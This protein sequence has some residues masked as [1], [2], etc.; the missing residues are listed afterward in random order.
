MQVVIALPNTDEINKLDTPVCGMPLLVRVIATALRSGGT[1]VLLVLPPR[2]SYRSLA[3]RLRSNVIESARIETL[4]IDQP[5]D[6]N[7]PE[8]WRA[9]AHRLDERFLWMPNDYL[10]DRAALTKLLAFSAS[11]PGP[12][13]FS[14]VAE[15]G[16]DQR[17]F[18]RPAVLLKQDRIGGCRAQFQIVAV[19]GQ[20]GIS[21]RQP[22]DAEP[23]LIRRAGKTT[24]GVYSRLNRKLSAPMVRWLSYTPV[25]PNMVS[26]GGLIVAIGAGLCFAQG[27]WAW[28]VAG[29][30]LFFLSGM[31]D[32]MDGMLARLKFQ[33]S[34]F[35]CW[36]ETI[37]DYATYLLIFAGM[38]A[39]GY[40]RGGL[41]Y[42]VLGAALLLGCV[43]AFIAVGIQRK[44]A[45]PAGRPNEYP[46]RYLAALERDA[47]NPISRAVRQIQFL[48]KKSVLIHYIML[49]ALLD[50]LGIVLFLGA[51][52]ANVAWIVTL[53]FNRRLFFS[54]THGQEKCAVPAQ[55]GK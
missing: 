37:I 41:P 14:G 52:G 30:A 9:I 1:K 7:R 39:G 54:K 40:Q 19:N 10:P 17:I 51:F 24:D 33:E 46:Q 11:H 36:L 26:F 12:V 23:E 49:F 53:Y 5:F 42:L 3:R 13:R 4:E 18:R 28:G 29:A 35:G 34:A 21:V 8:D 25:T 43:L 6:P 32:E 45:T 31:F 44:L 27:S 2:V 48:T 50:A 22:G 15:A 16:P 47:A 20:P 55:V 38:T